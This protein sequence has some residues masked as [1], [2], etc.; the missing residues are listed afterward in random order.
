MPPAGFE[1]TIFTGERPETYALDRAS[2]GPGRTP[3]FMHSFGKQT[4]I[5][6]WKLTHY[7]AASRFHLHGYLQLLPTRPPVSAF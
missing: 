3:F 6:Q 2:H 7:P 1:S 5:C 4:G